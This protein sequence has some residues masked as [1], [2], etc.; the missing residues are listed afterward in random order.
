MHNIE[1]MSFDIFQI[2]AS[3]L[4]PIDFLHLNST[5]RELRRRIRSVE[6]HFTLDEFKELTSNL[7]FKKYLERLCFSDSTIS[8]DKFLLIAKSYKDLQ[9]IYKKEYGNNAGLTIP[10][11]PLKLIHTFTLEKKC[12]Q[13]KYQD[14]SKIM[15]EE[16]G[17]N[18]IDT[19]RF[20]ELL[21][22]CL[23]DKDPKEANSKFEWLFRCFIN[24]INKKGSRG[25]GAGQMRSIVTQ[26]LD[27]RRHYLLVKA[28]DLKLLSSGTMRVKINFMEMKF[29]NYCVYTFSKGSE[30]EYRRTISFMA[31]YLIKNPQTLDIWPYWLELSEPRLMTLFKCLNVVRPFVDLEVS[32]KDVN[33]KDIDKNTS[34]EK[35]IPPLVKYSAGIYPFFEFKRTVLHYLI[36]NDY[37]ASFIEKQFANENEQAV[38]AKDAQG[39]TFLHHAAGL[40]TVSDE[41]IA[42]FNTLLAK[43]TDPNKKA[44]FINCVNKN[45]KTALHLAAAKIDLKIVKLLIENQANLKTP[46]E[47]KSAIIIAMEATVFTPEQIINQLAIIS[48]L[49]KNGADLDDQSNGLST[50]DYYN[51]H[52][53]TNPLMSSLNILFATKDAS[54]QTDDAVD[55]KGPG[56]TTGEDATLEPEQNTVNGEEGCHTPSM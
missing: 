32:L 30:S 13:D 7:E 8:F 6:R 19:A 35:H 50:R 31:L 24:T 56:V 22:H 49:I 36:I 23:Q 39:N 9:I 47:Q 1:S 53:K 15:G 37:P 45:G 21:D 29:L 43:I 12:Q 16:I 44:Q 11:I 42:V 3:Y 5:S 28:L 26:L 10:V 51:K 48:L 38:L 2:I 17:R 55:F 40:A 33:L 25:E 20:F 41:Q 18:Q 14:M 46:G 52:F 27:P 54:T 4:K 34:M